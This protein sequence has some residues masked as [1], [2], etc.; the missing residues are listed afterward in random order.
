MSL[1]SNRAGG[2]QKQDM[3]MYFKLDL[4]MLGYPIDECLD[5]ARKMRTNR[6][7]KVSDGTLKTAIADRLEELKPRS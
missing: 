5:E 4:N 7:L 2:S 1:G 6:N 3:L